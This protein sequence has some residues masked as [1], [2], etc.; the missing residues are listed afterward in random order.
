MGRRGN[1]LSTIERLELVCWCKEN[2]GIFALLV[3]VTLNCLEFMQYL[4]NVFKKSNVLG[5]FYN[6]ILGNSQFYHE[7]Q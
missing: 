7:T 3:T 5:T 2:N 6:L 4:V 1:V